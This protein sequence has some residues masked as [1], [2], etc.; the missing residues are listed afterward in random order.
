MFQLPKSRHNH[1]RMLRPDQDEDVI[2]Q[3]HPVGDGRVDPAAGEQERS[4]GGNADEE[5]EHQIPLKC[6]LVD[7]KVEVAEKRV[8]A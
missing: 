6:E 1:V 7:P 3:P 4:Q 2:E 8:S 5:M